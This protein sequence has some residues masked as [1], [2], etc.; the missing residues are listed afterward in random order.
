MIINYWLIRNCVDKF[1]FISHFRNG[2]WS[3]I[4]SSQPNGYIPIKC[5][6]IPVSIDIFETIDKRCTRENSAMIYCGDFKVIAHKCSILLKQIHFC[7]GQ[8]SDLWCQVQIFNI[9]FNMDK[10]IFEAHNFAA[11]SRQRPPSSISLFTLEQ[12]SRRRHSMYLPDGYYNI[13]WILTLI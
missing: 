5:G 11:V 8:T 6:V 9:V 4:V 3:Q 7:E 13:N 1:Q 10:I 12:M 2:K